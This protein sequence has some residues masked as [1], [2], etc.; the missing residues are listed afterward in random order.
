[1]KNLILALLVFGCAQAPKK[2]STLK[3]N[4]VLIQGVHIDGSAWDQL[5]KAL[6]P[7]LFNIIDLGREGRDTGTP[8]SLKGI[9]TLSCQHIAEKSILVGHSFGGAIANEMVGICPEKIS[10]I[11]YVSA[12]VPLRGEK[13]FDLMNKTDNMN[14]SKVVT[15]G[16]F[17]IIP[18]EAKTFFAGTDSTVKPAATLPALYPEWS[19]LGSEM[20]QYDEAKFNA[21]PKVYLYTEKDTILS[22]TTQFQYTS[23]TG[24]KN[25]DGVPTGHYPMIS[26][27][28]RL[29]ALITKWTKTAGL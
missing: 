2:T 26:N 4:L 28:E 12:L 11:I 22:L 23:R 21:I 18:K 1:M 5:K 8:A 25:S 24:I 7:E 27:P 3:E 13:P 16:K 17:K 10:K 6:D 29:A 20:I 14:Y 9:A 19:S 15:F